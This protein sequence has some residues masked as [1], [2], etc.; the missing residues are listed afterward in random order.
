[1][2]VLTAIKEIQAGED[3][4]AAIQ[5]RIAFHNRQIKELRQRAFEVAM[6]RMGISSMAPRRGPAVETALIEQ[7]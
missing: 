3:E 7:E 6:E 4:L 5:N 1:M 2:I